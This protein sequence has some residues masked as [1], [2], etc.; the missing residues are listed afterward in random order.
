MLTTVLLADDHGVLRDGLR[1]LLDANADIKVVA[2]VDNGRDAVRVATRLTPRVAILDLSMPE[3]TGIEAARAMARAAPQTAVLILSYHAE[4]EMVRESFRAGARGYLLKDSLS[5]EL[6]R[7]VRVVATG[8][9]FVGSGLAE[10]VIENFASAATQR[11]STNVL[12]PREREILRLLTEGRTNAQIGK[13]LKLSTRTVETYRLRLIEKL[14][15]DSMAAL[16]KFAIRHGI[17]PP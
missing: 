1:A 12:N 13:V 6:V 17:T 11:E 4:P 5:D 14:G 16:V 15:I 8:R 2:A 10:A 9:R 7:A 3:L